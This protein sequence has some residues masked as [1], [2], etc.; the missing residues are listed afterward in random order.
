MTW[1]LPVHP[2]F[3]TRRRE[4]FCRR[5]PNKLRAFFTHIAH[6]VGHR[7]HTALT[8]LPGI[9]LCTRTGWMTGEVLITCGQPRAFQHT[10]MQEHG[11]RQLPLWPVAGSS[12][13]LRLTSA[14]PWE[15][16][17]LATG[18]TGPTDPTA[19][20]TRCSV[21]CLRARGSWLVARPW[22]AQ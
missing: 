22:A 19:P 15:R 8:C 13:C 2:S 7:P 3:S 21:L 12:R 14:P 6:A 10:D 9:Y 17:P 4:R 16:L 20:C 1:R 5:A 18:P 11:T